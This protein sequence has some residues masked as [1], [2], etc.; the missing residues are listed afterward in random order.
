MSLF[1]F[2]LSLPQFS[3]F[4]QFIIR[5]KKSSLIDSTCFVL[6]LTFG[7][8]NP[9]FSLSLPRQRSRR[10]RVSL[11]VSD[12]DYASLFRPTPPEGRGMQVPPRRALC[13]ALL[14][15]ALTHSSSHRRVSRSSK[16]AFSRLPKNEL[17]A[18]GAE[19]SGGGGPSLPP[20]PV[21]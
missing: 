9:Q 1:Q 14:C 6:A 7:V 15:S 19:R 3:L 10:R 13:S 8:D 18:C 12:S 17:I 4:V 5:E 20:S 21:T 2:S 16:F 11:S